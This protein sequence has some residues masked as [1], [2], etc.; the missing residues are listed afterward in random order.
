MRYFTKIAEDENKNDSGF[1][2]K[3]IL[4]SMVAGPLIGTAV[5]AV[6]RQKGTPFF[7][8]EWA[9][10]TAIAVPAD[11]AT[12]AVIGA[13]AERD[14]RKTEKV[15]RRLA[16]LNEGKVVPIE[17]TNE[18]R[19]EAWEKYKAKKSKKGI[20]LGS[21]EYHKWKLLF[22]RQWTNINKLPAKRED[23]QSPVVYGSNIKETL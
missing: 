23:E 6:T 5:H 9:K 2:K 20:K 17:P 4:P 13:W 10:G 7:G 11:I 22:D 14:N 12:G 21:E 3:Y 16:I 8:K 18:E 15:A 1:F 19:H